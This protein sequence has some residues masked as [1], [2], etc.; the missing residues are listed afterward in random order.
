MTILTITLIHGSYVREINTFKTVNDQTLSLDKTHHMI[1][2]YMYVIVN[3]K[4]KHFNAYVYRGI[5]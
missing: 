5:P 1:T 2:I 4:V 3:K